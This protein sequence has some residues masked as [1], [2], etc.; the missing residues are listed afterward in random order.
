LVDEGVISYTESKRISIVEVERL[1]H[2]RM[3]S[4]AARRRAEDK[5]RSK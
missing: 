4:I 5:A 1:A 2:F 3:A